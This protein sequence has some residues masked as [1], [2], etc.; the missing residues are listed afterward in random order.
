[1]R[2]TRGKLSFEE[3]A[4]IL[5]LIPDIDW[6]QVSLSTTVRLKS[7]GMG[8][9]RRRGGFGDR[10][11]RGCANFWEQPSGVE[12][13]IS[14]FRAGIYRVR[15]AFLAARLDVSNL[16]VCRQKS[17]KDLAM[18]F[19]DRA[20]ADLKAEDLF[21]ADSSEGRIVG[22]TFGSDV[23]GKE[24]GIAY[25]PPPRREAKLP[26]C[27]AFP[28]PQFGNEG[29][30]GDSVAC[31]LGRGGLDL[32]AWGARRLGRGALGSGA[33]GHGAW[34]SGAWGSGVWGP[35]E[36]GHA[37][38]TSGV[39]GPRGAEEQWGEGVTFLAARRRTSQ[40]SFCFSTALPWRLRKTMGSRRGR[41]IEATLSA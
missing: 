20:I 14:H 11:V 24:D 16:L 5:T 21:L 3:P 7:T 17:A 41:T 31:R 4:K 35:G 33:W 26:H 22:A 9:I 27:V 2:L 1:M 23:A 8:G 28:S 19:D 29:H 15:I 30:E 38:Y 32:G 34:G 6:Y 13:K 10:Y 36:W 25:C 37:P 18:L 12:P 39:S 40:G